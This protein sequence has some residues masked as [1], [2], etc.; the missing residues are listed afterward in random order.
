MLTVCL[1]NWS[2]VVEL[3]VQVRGEKRAHQYI[4]GVVK[5]ISVFP[6]FDKMKLFA[7]TK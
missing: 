4:K 2:M 5:K 3:L 1:A 6:R 7:V